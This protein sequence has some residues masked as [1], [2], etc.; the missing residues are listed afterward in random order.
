MPQPVQFQASTPQAVHPQ[1]IYQP[2]SKYGF[3]GDVG[4]AFNLAQGVM[5]MLKDDP[6]E[7]QVKNQALTMFTQRYD[8][9]D[10][11]Q[12]KKDV[13]KQALAYAEKTGDERMKA[14][15]GATD[16]SILS[17]QDERS[18][19]V[20]Q[21][22]KKMQQQ[23]ESGAYDPTQAQG[24]NAPQ[25][26]GSPVAGQGAGTPQPPAAAPG[27]GGAAVPAS[28]QAGTSPDAAPPSAPWAGEMPQKPEL[29]DGSQGM[30]SPGSDAEPM[31][32]PLQVQV[33]KVAGVAP[34]DVQIHETAH[35]P[36]PTVS[37][38]S[39][40]MNPKL[41][42]D[43]ILVPPAAGPEDP[44]IHQAVERVRPSA[45][46]YVRDM[47]TLRMWSKLE[48]NQVPDP[49]DLL[50]YAVNQSQAQQIV[51]ELAA[52]AGVVN[53]AT[54]DINN[55]NRLALLVSGNFDDPSNPMWAETQAW[56]NSLGNTDAKVALG[57]AT[58]TAE[59]L[60]KN[61]ALAVQV[62][63]Q[64]EEE[65]LKSIELSQGYQLG[66]AKITS[67]EN[68]AQANIDARATEGALN[69][70]ST[71]GIA[72]MNIAS[73]ENEGVLNREQAERFKEIDQQ[74]KAIDQTLQAVANLGTGYEKPNGLLKL[75]QQNAQIV[76][77][78]QRDIDANDLLI[79]KYK[80][81]K[82][83]ID[84]QIV[85]NENAKLVAAGKPPKPLPSEETQMEIERLEKE[86]ER[87]RREKEA[88][89]QA[90]QDF[91]TQ[92]SDAFRTMKNP[93]AD[94]MNELLS[95][96]RTVTNA[97][98]STTLPG[99]QV[100]ISAYTPTLGKQ[101]V[102]SLQ[103]GMDE[104]AFARAA[105]ANGIPMREAQQLWKAYKVRTNTRKVK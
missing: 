54:R 48:N 66:V 3:W 44:A 102:G 80:N 9:A 5:G 104:A 70:A 21:T 81:Q 30:V 31:F 50:G 46:A 61:K 33:A 32:H 12:A 68:I 37:V 78:R 8:K 59:N 74:A 17:N 73:R 91:T 24:G 96:T 92:A 4:Q 42:L 29:I 11:P 87:L 53:P 15:F 19:T 52:S 84:D 67:T 51:G 18:Y 86:S 97:K 57:F 94:K 77:A 45:E 40:A 23:G 7:E 1:V 76:S 98:G 105:H 26:T 99:P 6:Q 36:Y 56:F 47:S 2:E 35:G 14:V 41:P 10:N 83:S 55:L 93:K 69:R 22:A 71:E 65:R 43:S 58:V 75:A 62:R 85:A 64:L 82:D 60:G 88:A 63:H 79:Q 27:T 13:A 39:I 34:Q 95:G 101:W 89:L 90:Q 28:A 20:N 103:P 49:A 38:A 16:P 72:G 100:G 25:A